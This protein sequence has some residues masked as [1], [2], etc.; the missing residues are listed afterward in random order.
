MEEEEDWRSPIARF[1][2]TG[3]L[4]NDWVGVLE[5]CDS[6]QKMQEVPHQPV[7][8]ITP[9]R[10]PVPFAMWGIDLVGQFLKPPVKYKDA[11][12]AIDYFSKWV[13][14]MP[15]KNTRAKDVEEFIWKN[16]ITR[17]GIPKEIVSDNGP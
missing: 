12:V 11:I 15:M 6:C 17:F 13:K 16:I 1:I 5:K 8:E 14:A 7:I 2:L 10:C 3:E 9:V 4:P